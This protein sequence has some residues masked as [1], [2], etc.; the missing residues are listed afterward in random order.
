MDSSK[1]RLILGKLKN[2]D[3]DF[4]IFDPQHTQ[5]V[6]IGA[7]GRASSYFFQGLLGAHPQ[8]VTIPVAEYISDNLELTKRTPQQIADYFYA[9]WMNQVFSVPTDKKYVDKNTFSQ[10]IIN[11]L[12][13]FGITRKTIFL[14]VHY[15]YAVA[16]KQKIS[17]IK[18]IVFQIHLL[19]DST[20]L[21]EDFPTTELISLVRDPRSTYA[22][23]KVVQSKYQHPVFLY[24]VCYLGYE[25][26]KT[27]DKYTKTILIRHE[28]IHQKFDQTIKRVIKFLEIKPHA[29]LEYSSFYGLP[30]TGAALTSKSA[31]GIY[32]AK[33]NPQYVN[34]KWKVGL[35]QFELS[36]INWLCSDYIANCKYESWK[37]ASKSAPPFF[38][39]PLHKLLQ[40][41][42]APTSTIKR[43]ALSTLRVIGS[44][45]L[46]G[47][48]LLRVGYI[49]DTTFAIIKRY[50]VSLYNRNLI[51]R[52]MRK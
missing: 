16:R 30:Y 1:S 46:I 10:N 42:V 35:S 25:F 3:T 7:L 5:I 52:T 2:V 36:T 51:S 9:N 18:K 27:I 44:I 28:D 12:Q 6:A 33:A 37:T 31:S 47:E 15:A 50:F 43:I 19:Y 24:V 41:D 29:S 4:G 22:S 38:F 13:T 17:D 48:F 32:S 23:K 14:A 26:H 45:P 34:D 21:F 8:I 40:G 11:Y 49:V 20:P 39:E